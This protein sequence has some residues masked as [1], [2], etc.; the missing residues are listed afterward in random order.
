MEK[1]EIKKLLYRRQYLIT[2]EE[3]KCPFMHQV[4]DLENSYFLYTHIDLP[5]TEF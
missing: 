3:I 1:E 5:Y 2:P 4:T